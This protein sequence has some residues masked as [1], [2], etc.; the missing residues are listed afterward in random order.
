MR[1][2]GFDEVRR[3][4]G[5]LRDLRRGWYVCGG[6]ALDLFLGRVTRAHKD[7]DVAVALQQP[8]EQEAADEPGR[9]GDEVIHGPDP[10]PLQTRAC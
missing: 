9:S 3:V 10:I 6:W 4:G 7:V 1:V 2:D 8:L 5:L